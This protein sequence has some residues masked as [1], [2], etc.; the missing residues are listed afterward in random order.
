MQYNSAIIARGYQARLQNEG[1][2]EQTE[3]RWQIAL[4]GDES[5]PVVAIRAL[6]KTGNVTLQLRNCF[7]T[8]ARLCV[9]ERPIQARGFVIRTEREVIVVGEHGVTEVAGG[10]Q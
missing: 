4:F 6:R 1:A 7:V 3:R 2:V 10:V 5:Q 9:V 8:P